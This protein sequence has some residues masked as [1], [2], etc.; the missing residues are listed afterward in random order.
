MKIV[1]IGA[2]PGGY[3]T[4]I[5]AAKRGHEVTLIEKD[6][7]GGT[8]LN[9]GCI[10]TKALLAVSDNL[11]TARKLK[12]YGIQQKEE[13]IPSFVGAYERKNKIV[14]G[15][16]AGVEYLTNSNQITLLRGTGKLIDAHTV[17]VDGDEGDHHTV[18]ADRII[19]ATGSK[20]AV[21]AVFPYDGDRIMTSDEALFMDQQPKSILIIGGGV[22][23]C[24]M[25]QFFNRMGVEVSMVEMQPH[26]L[27]L[28]DAD[29][30]RQIEKRFKK[31][32]I[33]LHC[34]RGVSDLQIGEDGVI[35]TLDDGREICTEKVLISIGRSPNTQELGLEE[36]GIQLDNRQY[37]VVDECMRTSIPSIYAIGDIV[38]T[39]QLAHVASKEGFAAV[40]DICG[41]YTPVNYHAV[42]RC[43]YTEPEV[44]SVGFTEKEAKEKRINYK[45][46]NFPFMALGK[47][48]AAGK[49]EGFVKVVTDENDVII[50][51][52]IVGAHATELLQTLT[53]AT[54]K[55]FTAS[56]LGQIIF[57]HPTMGEAIKEALH[58][59][60]N[61]S[62]HKV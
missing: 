57:P 19:L 50:G 33:K 30:S 52:A 59:V 3:E 60:H 58:D 22:I 15:L 18:H 37:I 28:E 35:A 45:M 13:P 48:K 39:P 6:A 41:E 53:L 51:G 56:E 14:N 5:Y 27:P 43:V 24:E 12:G 47:A 54:H 2:G 20:P 17:A 61:M 38:K 29:V 25:G 8:C 1:V 11:E 7:L 40:N 55:Q 23:G 36:I 16:V 62:V 42:P 44:A 49:T 10:P 31:D 32:K 4:A 34:G 46:G 9:R 26:L 21:P